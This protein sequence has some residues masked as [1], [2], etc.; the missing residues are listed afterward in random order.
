VDIP[1]SL[2]G[3]TGALRCGLI[4]EVEPTHDTINPNRNW[5]AFTGLQVLATTCPASGTVPA[6]TP[7][8]VRL[9]VQTTSVHVAD[10]SG[11]PQQL[12]GGQTRC[13]CP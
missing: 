6:A 7:A 12:T 9:C 11:R 8:P 5:V 2:T 10:C 3:A 13:E 4:P 1:I